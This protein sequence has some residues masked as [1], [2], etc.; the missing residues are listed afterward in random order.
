MIS[1]SEI[2]WVVHVIYDRERERAGNSWLSGAARC[3]ERRP[4]IES[5]ELS[6][7]FFRNST[8][9][10]S[11]CRQHTPEFSLIGVQM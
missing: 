2:V 10:L 3:D 5:D 4:M 11:V 6:D 1:V 7:Y 8:Q 9:P